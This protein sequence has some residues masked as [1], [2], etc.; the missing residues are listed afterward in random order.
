MAEIE[1]H[2][3][4]KEGK[5][6]APGNLKKQ[7]DPPVLLLPQAAQKGLAAAPCRRQAVPPLVSRPY[8]VNSPSSS[9]SPS[10]QTVPETTQGDE[11]GRRMP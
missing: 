1:G 5:R 2:F 11:L 8:Y 6:D 7:W 9:R 3:C 10:T 4:G